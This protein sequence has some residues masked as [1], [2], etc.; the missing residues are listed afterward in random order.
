MRFG[1]EIRR[2]LFAEGTV[3]ADTEEDAQ[4]EVEAMAADDEVDWLTDQDEIMTW[5]TEDDA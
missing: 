2:K 1:Y 5:E 4:S 3:D